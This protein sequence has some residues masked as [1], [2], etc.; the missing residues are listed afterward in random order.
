[1]TEPE[2]HASAGMSRTQDQTYYLGSKLCEFWLLPD[3]SQSQ[4]GSSHDLPHGSN[5]L[6]KQDIRAIFNLCSLT[7]GK[8]HRNTCEKPPD[9]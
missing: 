3:T 6:C 5:A 9:G 7:Q 1:V 2:R 8:Q 4:P